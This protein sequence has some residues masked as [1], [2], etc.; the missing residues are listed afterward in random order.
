MWRGPRAISHLPSPTPPSPLS[1]LQSRR[2]LDAFDAFACL[3]SAAAASTRAEHAAVAANSTAATLVAAPVDVPKAVSVGE[4]R[5]IA[6]GV[7]RDRAGEGRGGGSGGGGGLG[8]G[9]GGRGA[10]LSQSSVTAGDDRAGGPGRSYPSG[11]LRVRLVRAEGLALSSAKGLYAWL[12]LGP[13]ERR[14]VRACA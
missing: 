7:A 12:Q 6:W 9:G 1:R 8:G 11:A 5:R 4:L 10:S 3:R 2:W 13:E 14:Q